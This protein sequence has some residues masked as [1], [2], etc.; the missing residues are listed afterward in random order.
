MSLPWARLVQ[1]TQT[2]HMYFMYIVIFSPISTNLFHVVSFHRIHPVLFSLPIRATTSLSLTPHRTLFCGVHPV[3]FPS[4][5]RC[6]NVT[7]PD[8]STSPV[9]T[10]LESSTSSYPFRC[11]LHKR[12]NRFSQ[13]PQ[14]RISQHCLLPQWQETVYSWHK[15]GYSW[16]KEG[17]KLIS[18][19]VNVHS[20]A[21]EGR[22]KIFWSERQ[23][24]QL[25]ECSGFV[26]LFVGAV[27]IGWR[28]C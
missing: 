9:Y 21:I 15:T 8:V 25:S 6:H 3:L 20:P 5:Y 28:R 23:Q 11:S 16:H 7:V 10:T 22:N 19:Y 26:G 13:H 14:S 2:H 4:T 27:C 24:Q 17:E 12:S 18:P 1:Y